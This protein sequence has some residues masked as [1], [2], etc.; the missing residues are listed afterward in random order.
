MCAQLLR[1]AAPR[2]DRGGRY[3]RRS[4]TA[5]PIATPEFVR[6]MVGATAPCSRTAGAEFANRSLS[7]DRR[8]EPRLPGAPER[9][10]HPDGRGERGDHET[11]TGQFGSSM[12]PLLRVA[13]WGLMAPPFSSG[14]LRVP[15]PD[16][17][18]LRRR[19]RPVGAGAHGIAGAFGTS[20]RVARPAACR[21]G[22]KGGY[23]PGLRAWPVADERGVPLVSSGHGRHC[24]QASPL[25][26][27]RLGREQPARSPAG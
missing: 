7:D 25:T 1:S 22:G 15:L 4:R 8:H 17:A 18:T 6:S 27:D 3:V 11:A 24:T 9:R 16:E 23:R 2:A 19:L 21:A 20:I 10:R 12:V 5:V 26:H 14:P 13:P